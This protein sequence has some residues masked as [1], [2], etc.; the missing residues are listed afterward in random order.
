MGFLSQVTSD[1]AVFFNSEEHAEAVTYAG[2]NITALVFYGENLNDLP[3]GTG[4]L[5][6]TAT[7]LVQVA[8]VAEPAYRDTVVIGS[9]PWTV[10]KIEKG[11][12]YVWE[13]TAEKD[14]RPIW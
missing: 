10:T 8:D 14:E 5:V 2:E 4:A 1:L 13:I 12:P 11:D 7:L 3:Y 9:S 6:A